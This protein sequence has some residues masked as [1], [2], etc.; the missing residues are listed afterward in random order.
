MTE[1]YFDDG[2][3]ARFEWIA[4]GRVSFTTDSNSNFITQYTVDGSPVPMSGL[5]SLIT[6][7]AQDEGVLQRG[8][9]TL[10][11]AIDLEMKSAVA[12]REELIPQIEKALIDLYEKIRSGGVVAAARLSGNQCGGCNLAINAGDLTKLMALPEEEIARCEE[13]RCILV[14]K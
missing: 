6:F 3:P 14:R 2:R 4:P 5:G 13:C 10:L 11:S 12:A 7:Q 9:R 8:A 1:V